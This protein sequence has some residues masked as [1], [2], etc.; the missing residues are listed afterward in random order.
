ME[1]S[2]HFGLTMEPTLLEQRRNCGKHALN[3]IP[4]SK[5]CLGSKGADWGVWKKNSQGASHFGGIWERQIRSARAILNGLLNNHGKSLDTESLQ[6]L[7]VE[8]EAILNSRL[9]TVD[10]ISDVNSPAPLVP[11]TILTMKSKI[12]LPPA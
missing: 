3:R 2:Q 6:T 1:A 9:L 11:A 8:C 4:K 5:I 12:I 7:M 10:T